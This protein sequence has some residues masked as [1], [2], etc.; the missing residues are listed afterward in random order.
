[1]GP[2][3]TYNVVAVVSSQTE[4]TLHSRRSADVQSPLATV[5]S[6]ECECETSE[7]DELSRQQPQLH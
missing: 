2:I 3:T 6:Q 5:V 4:L 7:V 1:M